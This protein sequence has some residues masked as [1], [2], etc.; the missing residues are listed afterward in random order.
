MQFLSEPPSSASVAACVLFFRRTG[1]RDGT[2][3]EQI[4]LRS[5]EAGRGPF[6][7]DLRNLR[8]NDGRTNVTHCELSCERVLCQCDRL[9]SVVRTYYCGRC[10]TFGLL[11]RLVL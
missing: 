8:R 2:E 4:C 10:C 1:L 11:A 5:S 6:T 3:L 9:F 7:C